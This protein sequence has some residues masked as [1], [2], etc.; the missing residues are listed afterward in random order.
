MTT[1]RFGPFVLDIRSGEL[2]KGAQRV[3]L[4]PQPAALLEHFLTHAGDV[5]T[6]DDLRGVLWPEG[7]FVH[8]DHGLNSCMKQLRAALG[9]DRMA[10]TYIETLPR[11]GYRFIAAVAVDVGDVTRPDAA[12]LKTDA[13]LVLSGSVQIIGRRFHAAVRLADR[14]NPAQVWAAEFDGEIHDAVRAQTRIA[15]EILEA[16]VQTLRGEPSGTVGTTGHPDALT[17]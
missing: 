5:L 2:R 1:Y 11:R 16:V 7:T 4:R 9:D 12:E 8:F 15:A 14:T 6:R 13:D 3:R 17:M 10:P